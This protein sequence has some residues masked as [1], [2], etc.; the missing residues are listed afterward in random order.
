MKSYDSFMRFELLKL[1]NTGNT[2]G[3]SEYQVN[4]LDENIRKG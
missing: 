4:F 3:M 2:V 1:K